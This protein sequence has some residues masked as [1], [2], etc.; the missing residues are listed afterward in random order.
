MR[1]P[2]MDARNKV[3][4]RPAPRVLT[5]VHSVTVDMDSLS[6]ETVAE[7]AAQV[8]AHRARTK[9]L[10]R[11]IAAIKRDRPTGADHL[12]VEYVSTSAEAERERARDIA[13]GKLR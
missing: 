11:E 1:D 10:R 4:S 9:A 6:P 8:D 13:A 12:R 2:N 5:G 3:Q 7:I